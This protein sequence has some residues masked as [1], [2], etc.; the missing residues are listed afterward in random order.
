[1]LLSQSLLL[2]L[3]TLAT[4]QHFTSFDVRISKPNASATEEQKS[5]SVSIK[6]EQFAGMGRAGISPRTRTCRLDNA[7]WTPSTAWMACGGGS[8]GFW[9]QLKRQGISE[10]LLNVLMMEWSRWV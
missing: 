9:V 10:W 2:M 3:P 8:N 1:M 5:I 4:T 6:D 7:A